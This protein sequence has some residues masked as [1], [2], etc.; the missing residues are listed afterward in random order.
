[1]IYKQHFGLEKRIKIN[2]DAHII[3]LRSKYNFLLNELDLYYESILE[4][5]ILYTDQWDSVQNWYVLGAHRYI[6]IE[7]MSVN[8]FDN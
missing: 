4:I 6:L 3:F 7:T 2:K 5:A 8:G 1:M